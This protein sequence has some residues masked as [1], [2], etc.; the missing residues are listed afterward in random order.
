MPLYNRH[1]SNPAFE[2]LLSSDG[3]DLL[4]LLLSPGVKTTNAGIRV[5][6]DVQFRR[7]DF[8]QLYAGT[9]CVLRLQWNGTTFQS[10]PKSVHNFIRLRENTVT[11]IVENWEHHRDSVEINEPRFLLN[12]STWQAALAFRFGRNFK[13]GDPFCVIDAQMRME[14]LADSRELEIVQESYRPIRQSLCELPV[15]RL[16]KEFASGSFWDQIDIL[17]IN[18]DGK[19]IVVEIKVGTSARGV[20]SG[21]IQAG[22]YT[23]LLTEFKGDL[24]AGVRPLIEQK[25]QL[26]LLPASA[27]DFNPSGDFEIAPILAVGEPNWRS[28]MW[29]TLGIVLSECLEK[30]SETFKD[31]RIC[32]FDDVDFDKQSMRPE[33]IARLNLPWYF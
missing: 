24:V 5:P 16:P 1:L 3:A 29:K 18:G 27:P 6:I 11:A 19:I 28:S 15:I 32:T 21:P 4:K 33:Q 22:G 25:K 31:F 26:G 14:T 23:E 10:I 13:K 9:A 17:G 8:I 12:E 30:K 20:Y 7:G 2:Y